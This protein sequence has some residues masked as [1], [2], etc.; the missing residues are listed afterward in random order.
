M[1]RT[2]GRCPIQQSRAR[3]ISRS[4]DHA[5]TVDGG[6]HTLPEKYGIRRHYPVTL[7]VVPFRGTAV[8]NF[9]MTSC[10]CLSN[11]PGCRRTWWHRWT[12]D[13]PPIR[14]DHSPRAGRRPPGRP[15]GP[16]RYPGAALRASKN[17]SNSRTR[18]FNLL[19]ALLRQRFAGGATTSLTAASATTPLRGFRARSEADRTRVELCRDLIADIRRLDVQLAA[20]EKQMADALDEHGTRLR[21]VDGIGAVTAARLIGRTGRPDRPPTRGSFCELQRLGAG[22]DHHQ[23]RHRPAP[24]LTP[25]RPTAQQRA[26]YRRCGSDP[27]AHQRRAN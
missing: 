13:R 26:L 15:G 9:G 24:T 22:P 4:G 14:P 16:D 8:A 7:F 10:R 3:R 5:A 20:N 25:R 11:D 23:R 2:A 17:L 1:S 18:F 12:A 6:A 27:D 19:H 21:G